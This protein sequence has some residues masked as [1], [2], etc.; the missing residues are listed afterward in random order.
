MLHL[1]PILAIVRKDALDLWL[2]KSKLGSL[3]FPIVLTLLYALLGHVVG[4]KPT[5]LLVYNPG[6]SP[7]A[8]VAASVFET[9]T[10]TLAPSADAVSAA[11]PPSGPPAYDAGLV[12]P[13]GLEASLRAGGHPVVGLF[14]NAKTVPAQQR[15]L[16]QAAVTSYART[17]ASPAPPIALQTT[18]V[19]APAGA[20]ASPLTLTSIYGEIVIA[21]SF[22]AGI[23]LM[24]ALF[25][26]E[27][28]RKTLRLLMVS[29]ASFGDV[30]LGKLLVVG[31]CQL[32]LTA[33]LLAIIGGYT[34][35]IPLLVL[36][37]L[38]GAGMAIG[39]GLLIGAL[40]P[41][42]AAA[43]GVN[44]LVLFAFIVPAIFIPLAREMG[45]NIVETLIRVL[46]TYYFVQGAFNAQQAQGTAGGNFLDL[47]V[48][49]ATIA[50]V[51][52]LT[53]RVLRQ[54]ASVAATI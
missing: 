42:A 40:M 50:V 41:T 33:V 44:V 20:S 8:Q 16:L 46:P 9:A 31:G 36:Y 25:I 13:T 4:Q 5:A 45:N 6:K 3:V 26:E 49:L 7:L 21:L 51:L 54:Q 1:R 39:I 32:V 14:L 53:V 27:K 24:P 18:T 23:T 28:E 29:P 52:V 47:G 15:A 10:V 37:V 11:F 38:L 22:V 35:N 17:V 19:N 30:V 2:D 43:T 12:I 48:V 34:G